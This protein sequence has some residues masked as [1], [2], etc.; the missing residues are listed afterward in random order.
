M[1]YE[2]T[3]TGG[4]FKVDLSQAGA[5]GVSAYSAAVA[6]GYVGSE[7]QYNT[8]MATLPDVVSQA[9]SAKTAS[10][11]AAADTKVYAE[12]AISA[13]RSSTAPA[14]KLAAITQTLHVGTVVKSAIYDTACDSDNGA[15]RFR[16]D[17]T[18]WYKE[19]I[20]GRWL[21][22]FSGEAHARMSLGGLRGEANLTTSVSVVGG[23][24]SA[25]TFTEDT[26][27]GSHGFNCAHTAMYTNAEFT[28]EL[29]PLARTCIWLYFAQ[30]TQSSAWF[31]LATGTVGL[32]EA[33]IYAEVSPVSHDGYYTLTLRKGN[34]ELSNAVIVRT[35]SAPGFTGGVTG[36]G[37]AA[38][39]YRNAKCTTL[40][41]ATS[42]TVNLH[43]NSRLQTGSPTDIVSRLRNATGFD[44]QLNVAYTNVEGSAGNASFGTA[45][46]GYAAGRVV[47]C[48]VYLKYVN[49]PILRVRI[50]STDNY[51]DGVEAYVN[52]QTG[53]L[54]G[55]SPLGAA[56]ATNV[57]L[58]VGAD[59]YVRVELTSRPNATYTGL[60][61]YLFS[62]TANNN[63]ARVAGAS[64]IH[65]ALQVEYG[66]SAGPFVFTENNIQAVAPLSDYY[67][68]TT[69]TTTYA[70]GG[71]G[72][73]VA[74]Q[75]GN[76]RE[77]PAIAG[78]VAESGRFFVYD[79]ASP[80]CPLWRSWSAVAV[81]VVSDIWRA[82]QPV[83]SLAALNGQIYLGLNQNAD[84]YSGLLIINLIADTFERL[85]TNVGQSVISY[86]STI[87][88]GGKPSPR[89]GFIGGQGVNDVALKIMEHAPLDPITKLP[90]PTIAVA[91]S[92][93]V[94]V[95][96]HDGT[97]VNSS[98]HT[99]GVARVAFIQNSVIYTV[100]GGGQL[101]AGDF[102]LTAS[103]GYVRYTKGSSVATAPSFISDYASRRLC[104]MSAPS[105]AAGSSA[106]LTVFHENPSSRS[107]GMLADITTKYTTGWM[108]GANRGCWLADTLGES[109]TGAELVADGTF[110]DSML[111][112]LM[113][114][115]GGSAQLLDGELEVTG[116]GSY[117]AWR[118]P[119][120]GF[121]FGQQYL[122]TV[123]ARRGTTP[124]MIRVG[125]AGGEATTS[126]TTATLLQFYFTATTAT[127][128]FD[129]AIQ[130]ATATGTA[131]FDNLSVKR[132]DADRSQARKGLDITGTLYKR[133]VALGAQLVSFSN[134]VGS[135]NFLQQAPNSAMDVGTGDFH[136]MGWIKVVSGGWQG[137]IHRSSAKQNTSDPGFCIFI[138][139]SVGQAAFYIGQAG[140]TAT[141]VQSG[142]STMANAGWQLLTLSR[143]NGVMSAYFNDRL[144]GT[145][146]STLNLTDLNASTL[147]G[148]YYYQGLLTAMHNLAE[149]ALVRFSA[150]AI[151]QEQLSKLYRDELA[152]FQPKAQC[153][154]AGD[155]TDVVDM[156]YDALT[157]KLNVVNGW[158]LNRFSNLLRTDSV[159]GGTDA[160]RTVSTRSGATLISGINSNFSQP[161]ISLREVL[162]RRK[163]LKPLPPLE[164]DSIAGQVDFDVP[165]GMRAQKVQVNGLYKRK[166]ATKDYTIV[167]DGF[168]ETVRFAVSPG[169]A[170][171]VVEVVSE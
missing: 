90:V 165:P 62:A 83:T 94:T 69:V 109:I 98:T 108:V 86:N 106:S 22:R 29:K 49:C 1:N 75:R 105:F 95:I 35:T 88:T 54:L 144:L 78:L 74:V 17:Q 38:F 91:T 82:P 111:G 48:S 7:L 50:V 169:V 47:T 45:Q 163:E 28:I 46:S 129:F 2:V 41:P 3:M 99:S 103:F 149:V 141:S 102:P 79:L 168:H 63:S 15:W 37:A 53:T 158:G 39:Q 135:T 55:F 167:D 104:V 24:D 9:F 137:L 125:V 67:Y 152:L 160:M 117:P 92:S 159:S 34:A 64:Y 122:V 23:T 61:L 19:P 161:E 121:I 26:A 107:N 171:V 87:V 10:Q 93:C 146:P 40:T 123:M 42:G 96:K 115:G 36:L 164:F 97:T 89:L 145:T 113:I 71:K 150:S 157:G 156:S 133:P 116:G 155:R 12:R 134:F 153:T 70:V 126:N 136:T 52:I 100:Y 143:K 31:D 119:L 84:G 20:Y 170:W 57:R 59:G 101:M 166:G 76:R 138:N 4:G 18:A 139:G 132:V 162:Q 110:T 60:A 58:V 114:G 131:Y 130:S 56:V 16:C 77:F 73:S 120:S 8:T 51:V 72:G 81:D 68:N 80:D 44:G 127:H 6:A 128:N 154:M 43:S 27:G 148:G 66:D 33:G 32:M 13:W 151:S 124:D 65:D 25:G 112:G 11:E 5:Q 21:G 14:E 140:I 30:S 118:I 147:V 142:I 85:S